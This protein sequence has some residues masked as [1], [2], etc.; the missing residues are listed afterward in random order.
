MKECFP[1]EFV[2]KNATPVEVLGALG[3]TPLRSTMRAVAFSCSEP[4]VFLPPLVTRR[5]FP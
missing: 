2:L 1:V 4:L 3:L 5:L